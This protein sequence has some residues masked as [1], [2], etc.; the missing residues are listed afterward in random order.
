MNMATNFQTISATVSPQSV[1]FAMTEQLADSSFM[2]LFASAPV[3]AAIF[4]INRLMYTGPYDY[5]HC[6]HFQPV[7]GSLERLGLGNKIYIATRRVVDFFGVGEKQVTES[8]SPAYLESLKIALGLEIRQGMGIALLDLIE[9]MQTGSTGV[10][11][12]REDDT[13]LIPPGLLA[14]EINNA[15]NYGFLSETSGALIKGTIADQLRKNIFG[16]RLLLPSFSDRLMHLLF[17]TPLYK[18]QEMQILN[19][20][21]DQIK[22]EIAAQE[23]LLDEYYFVP[24][25]N[26][27]IIGKPRDARTL[28]AFTTSWIPETEGA[29]VFLAEQLELMRT[30]SETAQPDKDKNIRTRTEGHAG[31]ELGGEEN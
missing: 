17:S 30:G 1:F 11:Y 31:N 16:L 25:P 20:A 23:T 3:G 27:L 14:H 13:D 21:V 7:V 2:S 28:Q 24:H 29:R 8:P 6:D 5:E 15:V 26:P 12:L 19:G 18:Q 10:P 9:K 22:A 4:T